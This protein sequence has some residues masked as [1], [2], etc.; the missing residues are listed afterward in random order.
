MEQDIE[1]KNTTGFDL[2][3]HTNVPKRRLDHF[4]WAYSKFCSS[5]S[6]CSPKLVSYKSEEYFCFCFFV[7]F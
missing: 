7:L 1:L 3:I 6:K 4:F 2:A 5:F